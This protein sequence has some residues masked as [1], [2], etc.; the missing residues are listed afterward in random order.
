[1]QLLPVERHS[2]KK[3]DGFSPQAVNVAEAQDFLR[4]PSVRSESHSCYK[5]SVSEFAGDREL[6]LQ[7]EFYL[8]TQMIRFAFD[9]EF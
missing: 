8:F 3:L 5:I 1:M 9:A 7:P 4:R 2:R 6:T